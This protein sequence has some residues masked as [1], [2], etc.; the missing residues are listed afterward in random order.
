MTFPTDWDIEQYRVEHECDDHWE[1]R[2]SFLEAHKDKFPEDRL[3]CLAQVFY[4]VEFMG[5]RY[6]E[7]TMRLVA[8]LSQGIAD[9]HREKTKTKLQRTFVQASD[10]AS[11]KAKGRNNFG[12]AHTR[13]GFINFCKSTEENDNSNT[14]DNNSPNSI[15]QNTLPNPREE[16]SQA[17]NSEQLPKAKKTK[18]KTKNK[19]KKDTKSV[20]SLEKEM[21]EGTTAKK[22]KKRKKKV[23]KKGVETMVN[24]ST[25][26]APQDG[27]IELE[28][29]PQD[30]DILSEENPQDAKTVQRPKA[31]TRRGKKKPKVAPGATTA[32]ISPNSAPNQSCSN[33]SKSQKRKETTGDHVPQQPK[34]MKTNN[35]FSDF[36]LIESATSNETP[37]NILSRSAG[38]NH[39]NLSQ[40]VVQTSAGPEM[41]LSLNGHFM[42]RATGISEADARKNCAL[43]ALETLKESCYTIKIKDRFA[44]SVVEKGADLTGAQTAPQETPAH[45]AEDSKVSRM[46]KLMGWGGG[47]LGKDQQGREKPVEVEQRVRRTGLGLDAKG[48]I[49]PA[50]KNSINQMLKTYQQ[51]SA[52]HD[53]V[54]ASDYSKEER[55]QIHLIAR[56]FNLRSLSYGK[57]QN[58]QLVVS[59]KNSPA[60]LLSQILEAGGSTDKYDVIP[61]GSV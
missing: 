24:N 47:G 43:K 21:N 13:K 5:C 9:E 6:P 48:G 31:K 2:R 27:N 61:P 37:Y 52:C 40:H 11:T 60:R 56:R 10:A 18:K 30:S 33:N 46:M 50:F 1:L 41:T 4:N 16:E 26:E 32:D 17:S 45:L 39:S 15:N 7:K 14:I 23:I 44:G 20:Q 29:I 58:R 34:R 57:D 51:S 53:L 36:V 19:K 35:T 22:N 12:T 28:E 25:I 42:A 59:K 38:Q 8:Q 49:G 55:A 3:V 54:F